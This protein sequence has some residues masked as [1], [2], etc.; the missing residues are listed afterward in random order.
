MK[1]VLITGGA[2]FIGS[3]FVDT[4]LRRT[5]DNVVVVDNLT[6]AGNIHNLKIPDEHDPRTIFI[7]KDIVDL[8]FSDI[9]DLSVDMIINFAAE[10]HV[11]NSIDSSDQFIKTNINGTHNLL[12]LA[13]KNGARFIQ[14]STDEVYGSVQNGQSFTELSPINPSSPY[15]ASKA[16]ADQLVNAYHKTYGISTNIIRSGNNYGPRQHNEKLIPKI[17]QNALNDV[18]IP[19]Y[20]DG[21]NK[22]DWVY[23]EDF[24]NAIFTVTQY[25]LPNEVYNVGGIYNRLT[26]LQIAHQILSLIPESESR[27]VSVT[28]R[29]G[30]DFEYA[31]NCN[32]ISS[33]LGWYPRVKFM[34]GLRDTI[35]YYIQ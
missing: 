4:Y 20:G 23:V 18:E 12:E 24:C 22:R 30:H 9:N 34:D 3:H 16:A 33:Q 17:I 8:T 6:Y 21:M 15:S 31:V 5:N 11:D 13:R 10:T 28:D 27:V 14:I 7:Q 32:K 25:G 19:I 2:G 35:N 29:L 26:N 1:N